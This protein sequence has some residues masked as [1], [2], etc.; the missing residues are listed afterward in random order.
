M[1]G[2]R[3][4]NLPALLAVQRMETGKRQPVKNREE[5]QVIA[6]GGKDISQAF[7]CKIE[8]RK[9]VIY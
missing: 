7:Y 2:L 9:F 1:D 3:C 8:R 6:H 5:R 4:R